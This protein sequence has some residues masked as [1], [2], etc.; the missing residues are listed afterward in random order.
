VNGL[1]LIHLAEHFYDGTGTEVFRYWRMHCIRKIVIL[2]STRIIVM[3]VLA[4]KVTIEFVPLA[5]K[6]VTL[7]IEFIHLAIEFVPLANKFIPL[8]N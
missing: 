8:A 5:Y 6:F 7:A 2:H 4:I 3:Q 1:H